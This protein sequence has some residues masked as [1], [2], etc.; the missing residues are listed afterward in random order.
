MIN[1][2]NANI[3]SYQEVYNNNKRTIKNFIIAVKWVRMY[4][5]SRLNEFNDDDLLQFEKMIIDWSKDFVHLFKD[6]SKLVYVSQ[7]YII[8]DIILF[9][10]SEFLVNKF[11]F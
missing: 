8:G 6:Y 4:Q 9:L 2:F 11:L 7:S 5:F 3:F 1:N 10:D